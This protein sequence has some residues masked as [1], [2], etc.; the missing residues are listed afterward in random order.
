METGR[1]V[2]GVAHD[3]NVAKVTVVGMPAKVGTLSLLFNTL[4]KAAINV[5]I[6]IQSSYDAAE[7]NISFSVD[8]NELANTLAVLDA[9]RTELGFKRVEHEE[10]LAKVSIVGAGMINNPGVAAEMFRQLAEQNIN[11]KM[12]STSDIKVSCVISA[13][14][15][16][17]AVR[18]LHT[19]FGLDVEEQA[20]VHG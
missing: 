14:Q 4:A 9:N 17:L 12:V 18:T 5:D 11:I 1:I 13:E 16:T 15:T 2:S 8:S 10:G 6:I 20:V 7:T 3:D 19:A